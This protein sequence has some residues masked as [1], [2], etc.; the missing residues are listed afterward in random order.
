VEGLPP[1]SQQE[2]T[3]P[4]MLMMMEGGASDLGDYMR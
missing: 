2:S 3:D 4:L 1:V